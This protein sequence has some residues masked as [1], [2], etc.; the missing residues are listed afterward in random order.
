MPQQYQIPN[1]PK[2]GGGKGKGCAEDS[3]KEVSESVPDAA[4]KGRGKG[5]WKARQREKAHK[6][7]DGKRGRKGVD[8]E[9]K[10]ESLDNSSEHRSGPPP[11]GEGSKEEGR[12]RA[13]VR[14]DKFPGDETHAET[15]EKESLLEVSRCRQK[16]GGKNSPWIIGGDFDDLGRRV[17]A[18]KAPLDDGLLSGGG[19]PKGKGR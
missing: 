5:V 9:H 10:T 4:K 11:V 12:G 16:E 6:A 13:T 17:I 18:G 2:W 1:P 8:R 3:L 19:T 15:R 7:K 14:S